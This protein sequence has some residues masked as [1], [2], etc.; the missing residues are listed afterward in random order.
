MKVDFKF[1]PKEK[2]IYEDKDY[3]V[4]CVIYDG[5]Y[6]Y[7]DLTDD[8]ME[9]VL[10]RGVEEKDLKKWYSTQ[11]I[12]DIPDGKFEISITKREFET[13]PKDSFEEN[14]IKHTSIIFNKTGD[15]ILGYKQEIYKGNRAINF[16]KWTIEKIEK[17][18]VKYKECKAPKRFIDYE[19]K[20]LE[21]FKTF[22]G[23]F[24]K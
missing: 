5:I 6:K 7:Y 3:I 9:C 23:A 18:I 15:K 13:L 10:K 21:Q 12:E 20:R 2:V 8:A 22:I 19:N 1:K 16:A 17:V 14:C 4:D 24:E 11:S